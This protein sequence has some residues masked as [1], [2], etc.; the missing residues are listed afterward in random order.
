M[1]V[2]Q[3]H[4]NSDQEEKKAKLAAEFQQE[5]F[6]EEHGYL[7]TWAPTRIKLAQMFG[8]TATEVT[9]CSIVIF[10][11]VVV[12][13]ETDFRVNHKGES[14]VFLDVSGMLLLIFYTVELFARLYTF[15]TA[16]FHHW[17]NIMDITIVSVDWFF[18]PFESLAADFIPVSF[19]RIFR[20]AR[21][22]RSTRLMRFSPELSLLLNGLRD[23]AKTLFWGILMILLMLTMWS[24]LA[25]EFI[26]PVNVEVMEATTDYDGCNRCGR[27]YESVFQSNLTFFQSLIAG[28]SWGLVTIPVIERK[29]STA[30]YF[31]GVHLTV[32]IGLMN[33]LLAVIVDRANAAR[34]ADVR[35]L[36][37]AEELERIEL[38]AKLL[39]ICSSM[40]GDNSGVLTLSEIQD[41]YVSNRDFHLTMKAMDID[42]DDIHA[43][44]GIMDED[45]SGTVKYEEFVDQIW[46][47]KST[48]DHAML[49]FM[50]FKLADIR[51][52]L[53]QHLHSIH[54]QL[55][56]EIRSQN[57]QFN[58]LQS[59]LLSL[60][61]GVLQVESKQGAS[62]ADVAPEKLQ[63]QPSLTDGIESLRAVTEE[64]STM[65][66]QGLLAASANPMG[67]GVF[68]PQQQGRYIPSQQQMQQDA[69]AESTRSQSCCNVSKAATVTKLPRPDY[70]AQGMDPRNP[71]G[72]MAFGIRKT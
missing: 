24:I 13:I 26:H 39:D 8:N 67:S 29:P 12:V 64:I 2:P 31:V 32:S 59:G 35:A 56:T 61:Q 48:E 50:Q 41:G 10:N 42:S 62:K 21:L 3:N 43:V 66:K 57:D 46:K 28:D 54:E 4:L 19:F 69:W 16:Y 60:S 7:P 51:H 36:E 70:P 27:A 34:G 1:A 45:K 33:L 23:V 25:V 15:R 44:F 30:L 6:L 17:N 38:K 65:M 58:A 40:D 37:R 71:G 20:L 72:Q 5:E 52:Q 22:A 49:I 55:T 53:T 68:V 47:M 14:N 11:L 18:V 9:I 63:E